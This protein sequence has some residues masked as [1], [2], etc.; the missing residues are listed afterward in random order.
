MALIERSFVCLEI[1][2]I[3][4]FLN[5]LSVPTTA[6]SH[7][8]STANLPSAVHVIMI[9]SHVF[10]TNFANPMTGLEVL[11]FAF[12]NISKRLSSACTA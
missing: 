12:A 11:S 6:G 10:A 4:V 2:K 3:I 1:L 8:P 9:A 5:F 7:S